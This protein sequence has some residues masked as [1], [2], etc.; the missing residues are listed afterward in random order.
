MCVSLKKATIH[1]NLA[2]KS[3][4]ILNNLAKKK[5]MQIIYKA[6]KADESDDGLDTIPDPEDVSAGDED[7]DELDSEVEEEE[8]DEDG[9][10]EEKED[11]DDDSGD[12]E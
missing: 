9:D 7:S 10:Y 2:E 11:E 6:L 5:N 3:R 8:D 4:K 12:D 1:G